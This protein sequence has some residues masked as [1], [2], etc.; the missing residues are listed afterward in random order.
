MVGTRIAIQSFHQEIEL[1]KKWLKVPPNTEDDFTNF[2][3]RKMRGTCEWIFGDHRFQS[4]QTSSDPE[5][6]LLWIHA[7]AG[8]GKS[9]LA[10]TI[11]QRLLRVNKN[12]N[13]SCVYFFCRSDDEAKKTPHAI[14]RS[15]AYWLAQRNDTIRRRLLKFLNSYPELRIEELPLAT[16][17]DRLF[18]QCICDPPADAPPF[19]IY[20]IIDALDECE[21][22][23]RFAFTKM[24]A[25][26]G[27]EHCGVCFRLLFLSRYV[28]DI[29]KVADTETI[30][31]IEMKTSDNDHDIL[32]FIKDNIRTSSLGR[33]NEVDRQLLISTLK[34]R[35]NGSFLWIKLMMEELRGRRSMRSIEGALHEITATR[36][37]ED[38]YQLTLDSLA[39]SC[40]QE[41][42]D[43]ARQI[44]RWV[45]CAPR[46]LS[47]EELTAALEAS[48]QTKMM[49]VERA[50]KET[51]GSLVEVIDVH[52]QKKVTAVHITLHEF[53][54]SGKAT[55]CFAFSK[56]DAHALIARTC[57]DYLNK[58]Q[59]SKPFTVEMDMKMDPADV[60]AKYPLLNY[61]SRYWSYHLVTNLKKFDPDMNA[62]ILHFFQSR[63]VITCIEAIATFGSL[64]PLSR[65]SDNLRTWLEFYPSR[66][67][68]QLISVL[69]VNSSPEAQAENIIARWALD[70][71][72]LKQRF[73]HSLV[74]YPRS[75][76]DSLPSF[77]PTN[78]MI[79]RIG[80]VHADISIANQSSQSSE[81]SNFISMFPY[82]WLRSNNGLQSNTT[83][84]C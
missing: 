4:W 27:E 50:V 63:N 75:I 33:L 46:P 62:L 55:G 16:L 58:P 40:D 35:A 52:S 72:R 66:S 49:D 41:D 8:R 59:F 26:L 54:Q 42:I 68:K 70:F 29:A 17:W 20:W 37:L 9:V 2:K 23:S 80:A 15:T 79:F 43:I 7:R 31:T 84:Y 36:S 18:M 32:Q 5:T 1:L 74:R 51:C 30:P 21:S 13:D 69:P 57:L 78:S 71:R 60:S 82:S 38:I 34:E 83:L 47:L 81:W 24:L 76:H 53:M 10:A 11:I 48:M 67:T 56:A 12:T 3:G 44:F 6:A 22:G 73:Q 14:L 77:C 64:A 25:E 28:S 39:S 65:F 19:R 61:A 45:L